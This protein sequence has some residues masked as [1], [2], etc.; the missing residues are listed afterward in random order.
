MR[1][2]FLLIAFIESSVGFPGLQGSEGELGWVGVPGLQGED[3]EKGEVGAEGA[4]GFP[5][6]DGTDG[7]DGADGLPGD[8]AYTPKFYL[9]ASFSNIIQYLIPFRH[10]LLFLI[11]NPYLCFLFLIEHR[12]HLVSEDCR[13]DH[14][15][16]AMNWISSEIMIGLSLSQWYPW[17]TW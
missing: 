9:Q 14:F 12:G 6:R 4:P 1:S 3:G 8:S 5:G 7:I 10:C 11:C 16:S 2:G 17:R 15:Q 13:K